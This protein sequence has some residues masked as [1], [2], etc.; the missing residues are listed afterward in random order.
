VEQLQRTGDRNNQA[1]MISQIFVFLAVIAGFLFKA[2]TDQRDRRWHLEDA[3]K[4]DQDAIAK[5]R[6]VIENHESVLEK[7]GEVKQEAHSAYQEANSVNTKIADIGLQM[8]DGSKL[9]S[10]KLEKTKGPRV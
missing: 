2:F 8:T 1:F 9:S 6:L 7:L 10:S 4:R 5:A 3:A